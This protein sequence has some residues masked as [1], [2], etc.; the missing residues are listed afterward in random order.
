MLLGIIVAIAGAAAPAWSATGDPDGDGLP[1]AFER[2]R[3]NTDPLL[4]DTDGDGAADGVEDPDRDGL[5]TLWEYRLGLHPRRAD[6]DRNG[7]SDADG[8]RD[9]DRLRNR[10]ELVMARTDPRSTDSDRDGI[11]DGA[12]DPDGDQLSNAGEQRYRRDPY[13][14]DTDDDLVDDW[15]ED[16]NGDGRADGRTQDRRPV[17]T[18]LRPTLRAAFDR[19]A[20]HARC[21]QGQGSSVVI[22]CPI[23]RRGGVRVVLLGSSHALQWRG[24]LERL[25]RARGWRA[26][27]ITKSSCQLA[28]VP[29]T[30]RSCRAWRSA[31]IRKVRSIGADIV[32]VGEHLRFVRDDGSIRQQGARQYREGMSRTLRR[33]DRAAGTVVL[34]GDTPR[35]G[36]PV[37]CLQRHRGDI[38]ACS[39]RRHVAVSEARVAVERRA[40]EA[41]GVRYRRTDHL[42]CPYDPCPLVIDRTLV[43]YDQGHL[44]VRFAT[45]LWRGLGRLLPER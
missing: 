20:S 32:I 37:G 36:D 21:H 29:A 42:A 7:V 44:T 11:R 38:S 45:T 16:A 40:A 2:D 39:R 18:D 33:L 28:D 14:P 41:A 9:H 24:P 22:A 35:F 10:F 6:T 19:P 23:T 13:D 34:L 30:S 4:A 31:A 5:D 17:P 27:V 26:W 43:A 8:D 3:S 15:R 12:E 25:A 1:S